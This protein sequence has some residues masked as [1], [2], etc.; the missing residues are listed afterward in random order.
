MKKLWV[1]NKNNWVCAAGS[2]SGC[3]YSHTKIEQYFANLIARNKHVA[4]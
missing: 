3:T 2:N 1:S 4:F